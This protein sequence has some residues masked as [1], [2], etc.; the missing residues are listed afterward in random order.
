M[1]VVEG[2][3][4]SI[5]EGLQGLVVDISYLR[6]F[7]EW[8]F[9]GRE[10]DKELYYCDNWSEGCAIYFTILFMCM[11]RLIY[12]RTNR[13]FKKSLKKLE[14]GLF[15]FGNCSFTIRPLWKAL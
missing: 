6:M 14:K 15:K 1:K 7:I 13:K 2:D 10:K 3:M 5:E 12:A 8:C 11:L 9:E 4:S